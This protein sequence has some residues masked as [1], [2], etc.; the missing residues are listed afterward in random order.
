M[1]DRIV[2]Y[3]S[4]VAI[5]LYLAIVTLFLLSPGSKTELALTYAIASK[6]LVISLCY[7]AYRRCTNSVTILGLG[8]ISTYQLTVITTRVLIYLHTNNSLEYALELS[9][10]YISLPLGLVSG[11]GL[12]LFWYVTR[13]PK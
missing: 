4:I 1:S 7:I 8:A 10:P 12:L 13:K 6:L 3:L 11:A 9:K 2:N 5:A